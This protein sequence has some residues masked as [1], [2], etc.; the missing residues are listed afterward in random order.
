MRRRSLRIAVLCFAI[1]TSAFI[2]DAAAVKTKPPEVSTKS[3]PPEL[4][5]RTYIERVR[6]QQAAEV[7]TPGSIWTSEG[8]LVRLGTDAKAVR[9]HDVVSIVVSE[10]LAA[11]T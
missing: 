7:K 11:S 5:L 2:L 6:A 8:R 9:V 10:S 4:A 3:T 1:V